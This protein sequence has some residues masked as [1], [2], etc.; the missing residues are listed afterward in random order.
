M[1]VSQ[2]EGSELNCYNTEGDRNSIVS[3]ASCKMDVTLIYKFIKEE[4]IA[5]EGSE[6]YCYNTEG[7]RNSIV[8]QASCRRDGTRIYRF[9]KE[10]YIALEGSELYCYNT[11]G[12]RNSI[13]SQASCTIMCLHQNSQSTLRQFCTEGHFFPTASTSSL[14]HSLAFLP[15]RMVILM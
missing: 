6:I 5:V 14:W 1:R 13:V 10:K 9:I 15:R 11:E 8:S 4:D 3:Q 2:V 12:D 7:D